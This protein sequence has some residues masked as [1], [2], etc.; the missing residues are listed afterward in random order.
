[1][2]DFAVSAA[3]SLI[4]LIENEIIQQICETWGYKSALENLMRTV[5][6]IKDVLVDADHESA[7]RELT[8]QERGY[9]QELKDAV[10]DAD[11][12]FDEFLTLAEL[13]QIKTPS[14]VQRFFKKVSCIFSLPEKVVQAYRI[15]SQVKEI[16]QRLDTIADNRKNFEFNVQRTNCEHDN[17]YVISKRREETCSYVNEGVIIGRD[18]EKEKIINMLLGLD[19]NEDLSCVIIVGVG[20]CGKTALAQ[21]IFNDIKIVEEFSEY[22]LWVCV[23]DQEGVEFDVKRILLKIIELV[24]KKPMDSSSSLELVVQEFRKCL[25]GKRYFLVLDDV[26]N[27]DGTK[28]R[29]FEQYL[30]VGQGGSRF[31]V[32]TRSELTSNLVG[33]DKHV[34][35]LEGLSPENSWSLFERC[36]FRKQNDHERDNELVVIGRKI[37]KKCYNIPLAI[38]VVGTLL[39]DQDI[40]KWKEFE[41]MELVDMGKGENKIFNI[42]EFSYHSLTS[43][44][45]SCFTYCALFPKNFVIEKND[46]LNL[47]MAQGYVVPLHRGQ[48]MEDAAEDHLLILLRRCFFQDIVKDEYDDDVVSFKIHDLLHDVA[49]KFYKEEFFVS[50]SITNNLEDRNRHMYGVKY[51]E[52]GS[53]SLC[54]NKI[55]SFFSIDYPPDNVLSDSIVRQIGS[56][57]C[58]RVLCLNYHRYNIL[59][60]SIGKLMLLRYLDL[61]YNENLEELPHSFTMLHNLQTLSLCGC[62]SLKELPKDFCKLVKLRHLNLEY[63]RKLKELP[64]DFC[65]LVELRHLNLEYCR[66]LKELPKDFC[67]LVKLRLL[68]L[69]NCGELKELPKDFCKLVEL[70]HLNLKYC[71]KLACMPLN[72]DKLTNLRVLPVFAV[73]SIID[74]NSIDALKD[75]KALTKIKG[76][77]EINIGV[78]VG[79]N[80]GINRKERYLKG[81]EYLNKLTIVGGHVHDP[82]A[83]LETLEPPPN[84]KDLQIEFY[85]GKTIPSWNNW[86]ISLKHLVYFTLST[87]DN[88]RVLPMLS[89]LP[90]LKDLKLNNS[91]SLEYMECDGSKDVESAVVFPSL[92]NLDLGT[93][94]KFRGWGME[95]GLV[96][97]N[98]EE[99]LLKKAIRFPRLSTLSISNCPSL[100]SILCCPHCKHLDLSRSNERLK[101]ITGKGN[102]EKD[103][104]LREVKIDKVCYLKLSAMSRINSLII[105][106][107]EVKCL[108]EV[109]D[110]FQ[111]CASS[112]QTLYLYSLQN[113]STLYGLNHHLTAL[114]KLRLE[115]NK[116]L[117]IAEDDEEPWKSYLQNL[118]SLKLLR[119]PKITSLPKG[120]Q[121]LTSLQTLDIWSCENMKSLPE[122]ISCLSSLHSLKISICPT[123]KSLPEAISN[124]TSLKH[125][126]IM[127]CPELYIRYEEPDGVDFFKIQHIPRRDIF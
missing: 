31:M 25:S 28:W 92:E 23:A 50:N 19:G 117:S 51:T 100:M 70:R 79:H 95:E 111:S 118:R 82:E 47:W 112:L 4:E 44:L 46:L 85:V 99:H 66:K 114:K 5:S 16:K 20:G 49:Q 30:A 34:V 124:L 17:V 80:E 48:N 75:L 101:I 11:D 72:M 83:L 38:K 29:D 65:K 108:S 52:N 71:D 6:A 93:L 10:Y 81:M 120:M 110:V 105:I 58:L 63:C 91:S 15:S 76:R 26:W 77:I 8:N 43:S 61:S 84:L 56:W 68:D 123:M 40:R 24:D 57:K 96:D 106:G 119:L 109:G 12:L 104:E 59:P 13:K 60:D 88:L 36:A 22:R 78:H 115:D 54:G 86:V 18:E 21:L 116:Q 98:D 53:R 9:I 69:E 103:F 62:E 45:K 74:R 102:S 41:E 37:V 127:H 87:C 73:S 121:S 107:N 33:D 55:R 90:H 3:G 64:K 42:L 89:K 94:D 97:D 126:R 2:A 27:E 122:W 35:M 32:T 14:K 1:M 67:K 113:L 7:R 125:L 39:Y